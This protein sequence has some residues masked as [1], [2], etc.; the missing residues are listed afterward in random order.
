MD[1]PG[2]LGLRWAHFDPT[3]LKDYFRDHPALKIMEVVAERDAAFAE[4]DTAIAEKKAAYAERDAALLQRDLAYADREAANMERD[5]AIAA[6]AMVRRGNDKSYHCKDNIDGGPKLVQM[7]NMAV[8]C[9]LTE[10]NLQ[11]VPKAVN[12][13]NVQEAKLP[14]GQLKQVHKKVH[15]GTPRKRKSSVVTSQD[16]K[17]SRSPSKKKLK[18]EAIVKVEKQKQDE[19]LKNNA[20]ALVFFNAPT[21][22]IPYCS[23]TGTN[24]QCY[25]WG[26]G[27][28]QSACCTSF[29]STYPLPMN[30]A[31]HGSRVSGR[32][33][34]GGAFKK[35]LGRLTGENVDITMPIDLKN[36]WAKHGTN[37][38]VTIR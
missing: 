22:P 23:C 28:W 26:N 24:Q 10:S 20:A 14:Q 9:P 16:T 11:A 18:Q 4:R 3:H 32:K 27:G 2:R 36:H 15:K 8:D 13:N 6:L 17:V 19:I 31:K 35:L 30:P 29:I 7:V 38:Y 25:R 5:G 21:T 33:M 37:R 12:E 1:D 34:S